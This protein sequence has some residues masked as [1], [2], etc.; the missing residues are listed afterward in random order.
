MMERQGHCCS[1]L[2]NALIF[3]GFRFVTKLKCGRVLWG[4]VY[5]TWEKKEFDHAMKFLFLQSGT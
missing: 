5:S 3:F 2:F 4:C 1:S